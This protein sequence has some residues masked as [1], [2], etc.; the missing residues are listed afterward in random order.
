[1]KM[2]IITL[3]NLAEKNCHVIKCM[4]T[5][6]RLLSKISGLSPSIIFLVI[7]K[8][9]DGLTTL[10]K[11]EDKHIDIMGRLLLAAS[12]VAKQEGLEDGYRI[13]INTGNNAC[14]TVYTIHLH[15]I[16]GE[17]LGWPP[18]QLDTKKVL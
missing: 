5:I 15:V 10:F 2:R 4:K 14:Q 12:K 13:V 17:P 6:I 9:K 1:M 3:I 8:S 18:V 7:P 16:G 11:A